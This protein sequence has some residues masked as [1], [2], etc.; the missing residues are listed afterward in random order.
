[1]QHHL[2][3]LHGLPGGTSG[4]RGLQVLQNNSRKHEQSRQVAELTLSNQL[5]SI[6]RFLT[7][8][9]NISN[10]EKNLMG[11]KWTNAQTGLVPLYGPFDQCAGNTNTRQCELRHFM[12]ILDF[13]VLIQ[14]KCPT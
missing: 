8:Q 5:I 2:A 11:R 12:T 1:M 13:C 9:N 3:E 7:V 4:Q 14:L 10:I 6:S